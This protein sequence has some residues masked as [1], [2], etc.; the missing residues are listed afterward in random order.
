MTDPTAS[1]AIELRLVE[2]AQDIEAV[3]ALFLDYQA[4]LDIDLC[5][6]D[7]E[8]EVA[9]LPGDYAPPAGA[10]LLAL[11]DGASAG[12]C[13]LRALHNSDHLNACEMK[14]LFV[15]PAFRG[16]GLGRQLVDRILTLAQIAGYTTMLLDTL[17]DMEA[18]RA[19]YQEAGF[20][21]VAPYY[22]NP[23]PGA[24]YLKVEL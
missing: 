14:R 6:Q 17:S 2:S 4:S 12:C 21:E 10:L 20:V 16:F 15:R 8:H 11:V 23:I 18:A 9:H 7:F 5:F 19:L 24:H 3:R 22:H 1:A 13:G